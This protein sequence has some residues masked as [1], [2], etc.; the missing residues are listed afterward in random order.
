MDSRFGFKDFVL[1]GGL[2]VVIVLIVL[3]M[4]QFDRQWD[5]VQN[6]K[7]QL[8]QQAT[9]LRNID[10]QLR[11]G[12]ALNPGTTQPSAGT[13]GLVAAERIAAARAMPGFADGDWLVQGLSGKL[14]TLTPLV[15]G[16]RYASDIQSNVQETL[17]TRY[18]IT[19]E[20][21]GLLAESWTIK[22]NSAEWEAYAAG[23]LAVPI[24]PEEIAKEADYP[25]AD[26]PEEQ[27][28]YVANRLKEGRRDDDIGNEPNC[29]P[30]AI[31]TFKMRSG[32]TFSDG[33]SV[34]ADDVVFTFNFTMDPRVDAPR[35][36]A[37]YS[38][39]REVKKI[40][41]DE[42]AFYF[43]V[44]YFRA[45]EIAA[46]IQVMPKAFYGKYKPEEFNQSTGLLMGSGPYMMEDPAGW[47]Q[48]QQVQLVRNPR[49]W[50]VKS[51]FD[52]L[53]YREFTSAVA[54]ET[55]FRNGEI[56]Y[57]EAKPEQYV[58]MK[59]DP[60]IAPRTQL[61]EF[62]AQTG[63]YRYLA[64]NQYRFGKPTKFADKRVRHALTCFTDQKRLIQEVM[65]GLA[66]E[67]TGPF[68]PESKQYNPSIKPFAYD[69]A[70]GLKLMEE[71]G[72]RDRD[73]AGVLTNDAGETFEFK[74]TYPS[75]IP[76]YEKMVLLLKDLYARG[77]V[78]LIPDPQ[79]WSVFK[80]RLKN[81]DFDAITLAWSSGLESDIFQMFHSTQSMAGGD[82][83]MS[84]RSPEL[85]RAIEQARRTLDETKRMEIW[86][87]AHSVI[88][89]DQP[90][91]FLFF[92]K[93]LVLLDKRIANVQKLPLGLNSDREWFVPRSSQRWTK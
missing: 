6:I 75:G 34:T 15:S 72:W 82:N 89:D 43:R 60:N 44:P 85:D 61:F 52:R 10:N 24:T 3:A 30:A 29:P 8:Q 35:E 67:S 18:P 12:I 74:I 81:K 1:L 76:N 26:K 59:A 65:L 41:S 69:V 53:V 84:Y 42:V 32:P 20:W 25:P 90:Y 28:A 21:R 45:F 86:R 57:Y 78:R 93:D 80:D 55:G 77:K 50:T 17:C 64:W 68:N 91:T 56:D 51:A 39:I 4:V 13:A 14:A 92:P 9:D 48:G 58:T 62:Q 79:E 73:G 31:I 16:D 46:A 23:R 70:R 2:A 66:V 5:E 37:Y 47:K 27:K 40:G 83:F 7:H 88:Y 38:R 49:Y 22:D 11:Q 19:L 63:G 71:A 54:Q 36:R 87:Q 33:S